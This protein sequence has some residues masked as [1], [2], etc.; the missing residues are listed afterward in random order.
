[1]EGE[2]VKKKEDCRVKH[3]LLT[4]EVFDQFGDDGIPELYEVFVQ[5]GRQAFHE[6]QNVYAAAAAVLRPTRQNL[7][8]NNTSILTLMGTVAALATL[9]CRVVGTDLKALYFV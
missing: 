2:G 9:V 6:I 4:I 5:V 7:E 1:M 8:N 3:M